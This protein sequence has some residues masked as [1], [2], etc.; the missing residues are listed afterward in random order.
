MADKQKWDLGALLN[1][2]FRSLNLPLPNGYDVGLILKTLISYGSPG[3]WK[4]FFTYF[5]FHFYKI[6]VCSWL[7]HLNFTSFHVCVVPNIAT[8][9]YPVLE[10]NKNC[11]EYE[12]GVLVYD[13]S[14]MWNVISWKTV[15]NRTWMV[16]YL[17]KSSE[18]GGYMVELNRETTKIWTSNDKHNCYNPAINKFVYF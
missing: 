1:D 17:A 12:I 18:E 14:G 8:D 3:F 16:D 11:N 2:H 10:I 4:I 9:G 5:A 7:R 6:R 13:G 15:Q